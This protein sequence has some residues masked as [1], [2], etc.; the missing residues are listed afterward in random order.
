VRTLVAVSL[1]VAALLAGCGGGDGGGGGGDGGVPPKQWASDVCGALGTWLSDLQSR[2]TQIESDLENADSS[3][4]GS[5]KRILVDFL[6]D[7][8]TETDEM[9]D[10][11]EAAGTPDVDRGDE[12]QQ[13]FVN[14]ISKARTAFQDAKTTAEDLSTDDQQ[15]FT[16]GAQKIEDQLDAES[17][18]IE[19]TFNRLDEK[20]DVPD[21][22]KAFD[23]EPAC[24]D[25]S[26]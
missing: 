19:D 12:L 22:D 15:A 5:I 10:D 23:E 4:L 1:V 8:V 14:G 9:I 2:E 26:S 25:V 6:D 16:E 13:D 24:E 18:A 3:D 7:A 20:Y 11:V 17:E 21:L